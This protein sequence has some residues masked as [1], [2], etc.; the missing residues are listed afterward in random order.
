MD[1]TWNNFFF[2]R[3]SFEDSKILSQNFDIPL[4]FRNYLYNILTIYF[5]FHVTILKSEYFVFCS[6][7][8]LYLIQ[9]KKTLKL[10]IK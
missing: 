6:K 2:D 9:L 3:K 4:Y 10:Y 5:I 1:H 7:I 8:L